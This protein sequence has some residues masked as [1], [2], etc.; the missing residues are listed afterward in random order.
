MIKITG[1]LIETEQGHVW[2]DLIENKGEESYVEIYHLYV[3]PEFR[4]KKYART[5]IA[6]ALLLIE[7]QYPGVKIMITPAPT[8]EGIDAKRLATFYISLGLLVHYPNE[9]KQE[10]RGV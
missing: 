6:S 5:L 8:E 10:K 2:W 4:G 9:T 1:G 3:E 7:K